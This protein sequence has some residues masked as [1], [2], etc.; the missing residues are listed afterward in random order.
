MLIEV[1][2]P[3]FEHTDDRGKLIQ[4]VRRGYS[5][6][7]IITSK[8]DVFRGGH[9]HKLNTEAFYI[10]KGSCQVIARKDNK[11]E[12]FEFREGDFFRVF[13][14]VFHDFYYHEDTVL[15]SMYSLGIELDD[16]SKDSFNT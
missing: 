9:Y 16:G 1:L 3:D 8:G 11:E 12:C 5:Q 15:V 14:Y 10:L 7:N 2:K 4:L 13:P 6:F